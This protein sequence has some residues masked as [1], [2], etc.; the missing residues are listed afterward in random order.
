MSQPI[1][2]IDGQF[3]VAEETSLTSRKRCN[4]FPNC[5]LILRVRSRWQLAHL[6]SPSAYKSMH[7][8][9][10]CGGLGGTPLEAY[11][12]GRT[13]NRTTD[14]DPWYTYEYYCRVFDSP[15]TLDL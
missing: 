7:R 12:T 15:R 14:P 2:A 8:V 13:I 9:E 1:L 4:Y 6:E 10:F 3:I 5:H 11:Y